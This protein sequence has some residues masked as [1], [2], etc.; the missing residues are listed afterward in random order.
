M[1]CLKYIRIFYKK[2]KKIGGVNLNKSF[3]KL[4]DSDEHLS[5][6]N[7]FRIIK[8]NSKNKTGALQTEI[9]CLL[10]EEDNVNTTTINNYCVGARSIGDSYKQ[11]FIY[12][13]KRY[14]TNQ[15][16]FLRNIISIIQIMDGSLYKEESINFVNN[17]KSAAYL[18]KKLYNIA[19]NDKQVTTSLIARF[20]V[21]LKEN[22]VYECLVEELL[23]IVLEKK[24]PLYE[25]TLKKELIENIF[26]DTNISLKDL[27]SYLVLKLNEGINY[28]YSLKQL[29]LNDN[30]LANFELG[31]NEYYGYYK[32]TPRF[33]EA[34]RYLAKAADKG[35]AK[36]NYMLGNMYINGFIGARSE[37]ELMLGYDYYKKA[38]ELGSIAA[39]NAIGNMY[40][41][42]IYPLEE[43]IDE[44]LKL[45]KEA[46]SYN[47]AYAF[48]NL[49]KLCEEEGKYNNSFL[50]YKK[51]ASLGESWACN[52]VGELLRNKGEL[53]EAF[54]YYNKALDSNYK[55]ICYYAY[56]NLA[57][58]Y[59][60]C[61]SSPV[62]LV[63][64]RE[65][66]REY[67]NIA[68]EN[69]I[70]V[71]TIELFFL[72]LEDYLNIRDKK[73]LKEVYSLKKKIEMHE[74]YNEALKKQIETEL[75]K[76]VTDISLDYLEIN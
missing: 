34:Y 40:Y 46:S 23:F 30:A 9:F 69:N 1:Y 45:Y 76:I 49:G 48:N 35:H 37:K 31:S 20:N 57:K 51:A 18:A 56:Y 60:L 66:A 13:K 32:G 59:Y 68:S 15:E 52:K 75:E 50:Y 47:Y 12:K 39:I 25:S 73:V 29:A 14:L 6:G 11:K 28:D 54:T 17:N 53:E 61:G 26:N 4:N 42:G 5:L 8:E 63:P 41:E 36:A 7:L 10:F 44:A 22:K 58:Y 55:N 16:E 27:E 67:F 24:Q 38:Q 33:D 3:I 43:N 70:L 74:S 64:D 72:T 19:K 71:A 62:V 21:L 65:K 2:F